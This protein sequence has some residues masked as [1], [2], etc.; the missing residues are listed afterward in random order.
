[1]QFPLYQRPN[2]LVFLDD[3]ASYLETLAMVMPH[4]WCV[5]LFTHADDCIQHFRQQHGLWEAD[6]WHHQQLVSNWRSGSLLIPQI[7][8]YW[9]SNPHRYDL[10]QV[11]VVD[12]SMPSMT[13]LQ[14]LK[15]LSTW[16]EHR[17]LLTGKADQ[18]IAVS[19]FNDGLIDKFVPKQQAN[20]GKYLTDLL[21]QQHL[22][23][24]KFH[25]GIWRSALTQEQY[26]VLQESTVKLE[27]RKQAQ[28]QQWVEYV[29]V[30][31]PFGILALNRH[32]RALWLQLELRSNL[33]SVADLAQATGQSGA[34]IQGIR[35]GTRLIN[36]ELLIA[37]GSDEEASVKTAFPIGKSQALL[38]AFF[39]VS[40]DKKLGQ[41]YQEFLSSVPP[42][43]AT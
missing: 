23:P 38:G 40:I 16:P 3:D 42:R 7:L 12:F 17:V 43:T 21:A 1:M 14:F 6:V 36:T 31:A 26:A 19:A 27:L 37:I 39:P 25:E 34:V 41:T 30:P 4:D 9:I 11:C 15:Q 33:P 29:V 8:E 35:D 24:M 20:I 18:M 10:T 13:G 22:V 32:A 2:S 28:E 5:R